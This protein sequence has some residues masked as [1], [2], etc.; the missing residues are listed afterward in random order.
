MEYSKKLTIRQRAV[1][2]SM[3]ASESEKASEPYTRSLDLLLSNLNF[4]QRHTYL[5]QGIK[6]RNTNWLFERSFLVKGYSGMLYLL[7]DLGPMKIYRVH[8]HGRD[9][10][11]MT[12]FCAALHYSGH[13]IP[14]PD[15]MLSAKM[16]LET[17]E[18]EYYFWSVANIRHST[19]CSAC[20]EYRYPKD[21]FTRARWNWLE[22]KGKELGFTW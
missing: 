19:E 14:S 9:V 18:G 6:P 3:V 20:G 8:R 7:A 13:H 16:L 15:H 12:T 5:I 2:E 10:Y 4:P 22:T 11:L 1:Y 17:K 21:A